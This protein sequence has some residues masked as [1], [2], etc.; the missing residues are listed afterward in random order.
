MPDAL[1]SALQTPGL[2]A[3]IVTI[4]VAGIVRG[5]TGFGTALIF[6]PVAALYLPPA[7]MIGVITLTGFFSSSALLP[8]AWRK[9]DRADVLV[10]AAGAIVSA[11]AGIW[12]M[13][14]LPVEAVRWTISAIGAI[15]LLSL[16]AGW[17]YR[18]TISR[19]GLFLVGAAAGLVGGATGLTG[20]AVILF[21]LT[22]PKGAEVVRANTILFLAALDIII[23]ANLAVQGIFTWELFWIAMILGVPYFVTA[24]IGQ[25]LFDPAREAVYRWGAYLVI[26]AA[27]LRG[28]PLWS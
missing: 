16:I 3:L 14:T 13:Q 6:A 20:P 23:A 2:W 27:L 7:A 24:L 15:T 12:L 22:G 1:A 11:P 4:S 18:G 28:L 26:A 19:P 10:M 9:G 8:R 21:Y 25:R 5:F 17:R